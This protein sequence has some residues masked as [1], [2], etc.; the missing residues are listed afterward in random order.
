MEACNKGH[1][2]IVERLLRAGA[3]VNMVNDVS[4]WT[5]FLS[6]L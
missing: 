6:I 4:E 2:S 1:V 3:D 5:E